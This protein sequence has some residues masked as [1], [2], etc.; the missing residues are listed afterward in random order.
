MKCR[1]LKDSW[2]STRT[3]EGFRAAPKVEVLRKDAD[4]GETFDAK[5]TAFARY[6]S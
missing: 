6:F 2:M 3:E 4:S 1:G 5:N